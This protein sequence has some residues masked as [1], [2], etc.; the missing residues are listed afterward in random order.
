MA[1]VLLQAEDKQTVEEQAHKR[2][3]L[4]LSQHMLE[5]ARFR[6]PWRLIVHVAAHV[7]GCMGAAMQ[8]RTCAA[9]PVLLN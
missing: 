6:T 9:C 1:A 2:D 8:A 7:H 3:Q 4:L 5:D